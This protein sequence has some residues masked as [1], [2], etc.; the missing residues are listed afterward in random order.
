MSDVKPTT[1]EERV[2]WASSPLDSAVVVVAHPDD[3]VLWFSSI[4]EKADKVLVCYL[5]SKTFPELNKGRE[6]AL[7]EHPLKNLSCLGLPESPVYAPKRWKGYGFVQFSRAV[8]RYAWERVV[9]EVFH[10]N[11]RMLTAALR[12]HLLGVKNVITHSPWGEYGHRE[13]RRVYSVVKTLQEEMR[14]DLW[15]TTYCSQETMDAARRHLSKSRGSIIRLQTN[16]DLARRAAQVY[17]A[18]GCWTWHDDYQWCEQEA[19]ATDEQTESLG[20]G[21]AF[22][23]PLNLIVD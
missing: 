12:P 17:K 16:R 9:G 7:R 1:G 11:H 10:K 3:E 8:G 21:P 18:N 4:L 2:E 23:A 13:H 6:K 20:M 15:Y 5:R 19:F 14:F 22:V